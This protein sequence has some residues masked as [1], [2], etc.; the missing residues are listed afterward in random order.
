[1]DVEGKLGGMG[2]RVG[3]WE[4]NGEDDERDVIGL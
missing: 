3:D 2:R 1:M 4:G